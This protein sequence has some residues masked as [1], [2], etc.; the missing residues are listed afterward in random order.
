M[1]E[2]ECPHTLNPIETYLQKASNQLS[3]KEKQA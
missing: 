1:T 2:K 3:E